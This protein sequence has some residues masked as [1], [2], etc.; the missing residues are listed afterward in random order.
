LF[1]ITFDGSD[2]TENKIGSIEKPVSQISN[3]QMPSNI[4]QVPNTNTPSDTD[5]ISNIDQNN[6]D[7]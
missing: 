6:K 7:A 2:L 1:G 3:T 4:D 5:Q